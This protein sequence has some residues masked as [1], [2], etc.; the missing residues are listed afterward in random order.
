LRNH[1]LIV[2][3]PRA[4]RGEY[5]QGIHVNGGTVQLGRLISR[6]S[7]RKPLDGPLRPVLVANNLAA[8]ILPHER[9]NLGHNL[10]RIE[11]RTPF[12]K[13][14]E[15]YFTVTFPM[16]NSRRETVIAPARGIAPRNIVYIPGRRPDENPTI[17]RRIQ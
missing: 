4:A 6:P 11:G 8:P 17:D 10:A 15:N 13:S 2:E 9:D 16:G 3:Q 12:V 1:L 5:W 7:P 14:V